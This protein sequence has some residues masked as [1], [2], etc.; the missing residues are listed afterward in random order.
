MHGKNQVE[1]QKVYHDF[2]ERMKDHKI[3]ILIQKMMTHQKTVKKSTNPAN[4]LRRLKKDYG[5]SESGQSEYDE[6]DDRQ[7]KNQKELDSSLEDF[8]AGL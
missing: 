8:K 2:K 4:E 7:D 3:G 5:F 1:K 6:D